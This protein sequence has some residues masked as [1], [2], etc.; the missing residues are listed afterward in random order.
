MRALIAEDEVHLA[1]DLQRRLARLWPELDVSL[2]VHDGLAARQSL[3]E[4]APD[5]AFL[6]ILM[7]GITGLEAAKSAPDCCRVVF[8]TAYEEQAVAAFELAA[9][10]YLLKPVADER[11]AACVARLRQA[12]TLATT[13]LL[14][15]LQEMMPETAPTVSYLRWLRVQ[16][17]GE[18]LLVPVEEVCYFRSADKYTAVVTSTHEYL[19]RTSLKELLQRL[20]PAHF[21]QIHRGTIVHVRAVAAAR[22]NLLGRLVL[23]LHSRSETLP[24]SRKY[25]HLFQHM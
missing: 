7:P 4:Q 15:R 11:L 9:A 22:R 18:V 10:D 20:D 1:R 19:L 21:W 5:L 3:I 16:E 12:P 2:M 13:T 24:V 17:G 25:A 23:A 6:D 8:V 14:A